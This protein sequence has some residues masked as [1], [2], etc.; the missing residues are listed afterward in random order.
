MKYEIDDAI[1]W[2]EDSLELNL[3]EKADLPL[4]MLVLTSISI[5]NG[6]W[7]IDK[8]CKVVHKVENNIFANS[9]IGTT[10]QDIDKRERSDFDQ[11]F[12]LFLTYSYYFLFLIFYKEIS[13][14]HLNLSW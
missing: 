4:I 14:F 10:I 3:L 1:K 8:D 7:A 5:V 12:L 9:H 6:N 2:V 13:L 11:V